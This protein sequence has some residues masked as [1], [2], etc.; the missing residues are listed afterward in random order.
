MPGYGIP[1][2]RLG[3]MPQDIALYPH[4][5]IREILLYFGR[6]YGM[7]TSDIL[8]REEFLTKFLQLPDSSKRISS[9]RLTFTF[10]YFTFFV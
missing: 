4:F 6:I 2:K 3:Y 10:Q 5:T 1:G 8:K 7:S 9:L